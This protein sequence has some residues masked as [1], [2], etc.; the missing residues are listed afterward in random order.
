MADY[1]IIDGVRLD[2]SLMELA[3][4]SVQGAGDGRVSF[5]D[6][7]VIWA[8]AM[9]DGKITVV[10]NRTVKYILDHFKCTDKAK[11]FLAEHVYRT[12]GGVQY[13]L[14]L[15]QTAE[16]LVDGPGDGRISFDDAGLI[17]GLADADGIITDVERRTL[18]YI[19]DNFNC[20][21]K[22]KSFLVEKLG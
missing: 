2:K 22:A 21:D 1:R 11:A 16:K 19:I 18:Q 3:E 12:I 10:E 15:L 20:T 17:W 13:D 6:A 7:Q 5:E 9:A 4:K 14:A 8:D